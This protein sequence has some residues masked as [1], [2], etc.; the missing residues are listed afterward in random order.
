MIIRRKKIKLN[1]NTYHIGVYTYHNGR[2]RLRYENNKECHDITLNLEDTYLDKGKVFLDP[3]IKTNGLMK[4]LRKSR[5]IRDICG[6]I[7]Y[8][9]VDI[10]IATLNM[11]ILRQY[12]S[13]G[14]EKHLSKVATYEE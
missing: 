6:V 4:V 9:Y 2:I 3:F 14:V 11:G 8:N 1:N 7:N 10:P 5:I 12:D 13:V